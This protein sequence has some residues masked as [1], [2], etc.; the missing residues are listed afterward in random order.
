MPIISGRNWRETRL[1]TLEAALNGDLDSEER[2]AIQTE[3][4]ELRRE[5]KAG[6]RRRFRWLIIGGHLPEP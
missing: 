4:D 2:A 1:H 5:A 3:I 6:K